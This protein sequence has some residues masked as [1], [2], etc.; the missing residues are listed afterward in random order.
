MATF[1]LLN[2]IFVFYLCDPPPFF[3][4]LRG[5]ISVKAVKKEV[6]KKLR[7]LLADLPLPPELPGGDDLS[8]SPEEKKTATQLHNKRRPKYVLALYLLLI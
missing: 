1:L 6:E 8:K 4:S 3:S 7:C 5:N 2:Q